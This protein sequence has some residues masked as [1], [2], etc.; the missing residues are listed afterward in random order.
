MSNQH[1]SARAESEAGTHSG[2]R[3]AYE[4]CAAS[5]LRCRLAQSMHHLHPPAGVHCR[6]RANILRRVSLPFAYGLLFCLGTTMGVSA[7]TSRSRPCR[8]RSRSVSTARTRGSSDDCAERMAK[9]KGRFQFLPHPLLIKSP[10][11]K[12]G[13]VT[14]SLKPLAVR[15]VNFSFIVTQG[16]RARGCREGRSVGPALRPTDGRWVG[17]LGGPAVRRWS[18]YNGL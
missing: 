16:G 1:R 9:T 12:Q 13:V 5:L 15:E 14:S 3:P 17:R 10:Q 4:S 8:W 11:L 18:G 2:Q 7:L 6:E